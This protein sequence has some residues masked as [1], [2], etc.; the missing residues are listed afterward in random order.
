MDFIEGELRSHLDPT[1]IRILKKRLA[2]GKITPQVFKD[3]LRRQMVKYYFQT[4][5][6][7]LAQSWETFRRSVKIKFGLG[8]NTDP[9]RE[10]LLESNHHKRF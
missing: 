5:R 6:H 1:G 7:P 2:S 8:S 4:H 3:I 9:A 10:A